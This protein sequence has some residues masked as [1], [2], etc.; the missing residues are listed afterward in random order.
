[1]GFANIDLPQI[2][3]VGA[4]S[5]GKSSVL[6]N[7]VREPLLEALPLFVLLSHRLAWQRSLRVGMACLLLS[8]W[9][10]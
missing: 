8:V 1:M 7:L 6:E 5:A 4:Q 9:T 2:A 3:V 10:G